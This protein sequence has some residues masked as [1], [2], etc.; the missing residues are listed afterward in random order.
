VA[1]RYATLFG[2]GTAGLRGESAAG[3]G[4]VL[5]LSPRLLPDDDWLVAETARLAEEL[6]LPVVVTN[7]V[8][9][10]K[11]E[12]QEIHDVLTAIRH[13]RSLETLLQARAGRGVP[14]GH[15]LLA[16]PLGEPPTASVDPV[17]RGVAR[18]TAASSEIAAGC[19]VDSRSSAIASGLRRA[20]GRDAV[21]PPLVAVLG[22]A[23]RRYHPMTP[24]VVRQ[25]AHELT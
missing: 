6:G 5:E 20:Q 4:F 10:A 19:R 3:S 15:E 13:D 25:L 22:W 1:E 17:P 7:D 12:D 2:H 24:A 23:K 21:Q 11:P 18:G 14:G 16:L 9:Y 8:H